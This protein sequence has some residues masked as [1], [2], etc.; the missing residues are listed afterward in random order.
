MNLK[1]KTYNKHILLYNHD[2]YVFN[3]DYLATWLPDTMFTVKD[4]LEL[5]NEYSDCLNEID[6]CSTL[7]RLQSLR[8]RNL[9]ILSAVRENMRALEF[10]DGPVIQGL[11]IAQQ[12]QGMGRGSLWL[13]K[14]IKDKI[15]QLVSN[16]REKKMVKSGIKQAVDTL[17]SHS[18]SN[19]AKSGW[20]HDVGTGLN[21]IDVIVNP[22]DAYERLLG[23]ALVAQ[24]L[25]LAVSELAEAMEG[26]R[27]GLMDD[28]L[29]HRQMLEVECADLML[30]LC[31]LAGAL[32]LDLGGAVE[33]KLEF[34]RTRPDHQLENRLAAGGKSY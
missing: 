24:K 28:K 9:N 25:M 13:N 2:N 27:K 23:K 33:E 18:H 20:W 8:R 3:Y 15:V 17:V 32:N 11:W 16:T 4:V 29:P 30:R 14:K 6:S 34:N 21:L 10:V 12:C 5:S 1:Q 22:K 26:H 31:D 19:S 7:P